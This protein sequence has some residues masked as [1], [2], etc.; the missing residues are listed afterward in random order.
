M[1]VIDDK[2]Q[3]LLQQLPYEKQVDLASCLQ[4]K[5]QDGTVMNPSGWMV[6][7]CIAAGAG[8]T[9]AM[10]GNP[11]AMSG[12]TMAMGSM[13]GR[14]PSQNVGL[15]TRST[16]PLMPQAVPMAMMILDEKA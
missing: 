13:S 12:S 8:N 4:V 1:M 15:A 7:S 2:A 11:M 16:T 6:R 14:Y 3:T 10:G 5:V 9:T